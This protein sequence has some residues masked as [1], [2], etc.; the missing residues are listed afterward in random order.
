MT[1]R[2]KSD[3]LFAFGI[4]LALTLAFKLR[5]LLLLIYVSALFAVVTTPFVQRVQKQ[6]GKSHL[7]K[8]VS[9]ML[10]LCHRS[11]NRSPDRLVRAAANFQRHPSTG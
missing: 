10:L 5:Q 2:H 9:L 3:I 4:A 1:A 8:G 6:F 7:G 11:H